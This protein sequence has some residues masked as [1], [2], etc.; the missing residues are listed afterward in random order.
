MFF[1]YVAKFLT[2]AQRDGV[3]GV[4]R[5]TN[6]YVKNFGEHLDDAKLKELFDKFGIITSH[7]VIRDAEGKSRGFGFVA[8]EKAEQALKAVGE[9]NGYELPD[10]DGK[11]LTVCR[12][13]KKAERQAEL[14]R[15]YALWKS[16]LE[17]KCKGANLYVKNLDETVTDEELHKIFEEYGTITSAK[18]RFFFVSKYILFGS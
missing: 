9:M 7:I 1:S 6:V 15:K 13:Q 5:F 11:K 2:R 10:S 8:F 18:V 14:K 4:A 3:D 17:K 12:A 16:D